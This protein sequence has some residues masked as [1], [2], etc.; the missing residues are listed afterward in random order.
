MGRKW[1]N[2]H[3][4]AGRLGNTPRIRLSS[5]LIDVLARELAECG[6]MAGR[7]GYGWIVD[8]RP[9]SPRY[10][11]NCY[12]RKREKFATEV[13]RNTEAFIEAET[14]K[15]LSLPDPKPRYLEYTKD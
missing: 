9:A 6:S 1:R 12:Q 13:R 11:L 2:R 4:T 5:V 8:W 15:L 14:S 10:P 3:A 7:A